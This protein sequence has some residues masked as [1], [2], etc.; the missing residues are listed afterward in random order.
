MKNLTEKEVFDLINKGQ[1][2]NT[3]VQ[4]K[5]DWDKAL[6]SITAK[7]TKTPI[8]ISEVHNLINQVVNRGRV[9][10]KLM[11]LAKNGKMAIIYDGK[12]F[13]STNPEHIKAYQAKLKELSQ[14]EKVKK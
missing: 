10:M 3:N 5:C 6:I 12:Y 11:E 7:A 4:G 9:K 13:V 2:K 14:V 1:I 8:T